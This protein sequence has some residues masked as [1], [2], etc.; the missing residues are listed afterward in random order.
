MA[1]YEFRCPECSFTIEKVQP[2]SNP[3]LRCPKCGIDMNKVVGAPA[4]IRIKGQGYPAR[5]KWMD[6]WTPDS[7]SFRTG[8]L[9]GAKY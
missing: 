3:P 1:L 9:H 4:L 2:F 6:N 5:R 8:S 7:K